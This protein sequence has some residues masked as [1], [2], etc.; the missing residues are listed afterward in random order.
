MAEYRSDVEE[1][2]DRSVWATHC[3]FG[4][5]IQDFRYYTDIFGFTTCDCGVLRDANCKPSS[6]LPLRGVLSRRLAEGDHS[7]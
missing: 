4:D 3:G 7:S 2:K 5:N 1:Y 6:D